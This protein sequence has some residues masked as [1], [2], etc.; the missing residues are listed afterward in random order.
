[1]TRGT[2]PL[3]LASRLIA[4][5]VNRESPCQWHFLSLSVTYCGILRK[6]YDLHQLALFVHMLEE[7]EQCLKNFFRNRLSLV[8]EQ[9]DMLTVACQ[10]FQFLQN[11]VSQFSRRFSCNIQL[12]PD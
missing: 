12:L 1:M 7:K 4:F 5:G 11:S 8:N 3:A 2:P 10:D 6:K 9:H